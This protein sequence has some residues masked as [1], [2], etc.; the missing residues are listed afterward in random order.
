MNNQ[1]KIS[2]TINALLLAL[3]KLG[4]KGDFHKLFKI[5]YFAD[6]KHLL[7]Y[8]S[9]ITDDNYIAMNNGP[10]PSMTYDILKALRG[11]GLLETHKSTFEEYF[12]LLSK[13]K[14]ESQVSP[15]LEELSETQQECILESI[16]ENKNLHFNQLTQKSHDSAWSKADRDCEMNLQ[17]I[18]KAAGANNQLINYINDSLENQR[19]IFE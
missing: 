12:K 1:E 16:S 13:Y 19:A 2:S 7:R 9:L 10:V 5:L 11:E 6:Q 8:G 15:D 14:V 17:E 18:A 3:E 4:G